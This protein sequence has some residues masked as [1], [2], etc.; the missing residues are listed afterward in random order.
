MHQLETGSWKEFLKLFL[1]PENY[2]SCS[3]RD[4]KYTS[5]LPNIG[6]LV[7]GSDFHYGTDL[8]FSTHASPVIQKDS[9]LKV[10]EETE[11]LKD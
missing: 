9:P 5:L 2:L 3:M 10:T 8:V 7:Y 6:R 1:K 4:G 11:I